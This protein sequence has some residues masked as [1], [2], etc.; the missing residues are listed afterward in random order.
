MMRDEQNLW[1]FLFLLFFIAVFGS[2]LWWL[3]GS[4]RLPIAIDFFD[5]VLVVLAAF[6]LTRLFVYDRILQFFRDWFLDV[7]TVSEEGEVLILR[8]RA[9]RGPRRTITELLGCP[10]CFG[11]WSAATVTFFYFATPLA[12]FPIFV[13]AVAGVTTLF[14]LGANLLGWHTELTKREVIAIDPRGIRGVD[15]DHDH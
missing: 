12:W 8:N 7:S 15:L 9:S 3:W 1:N 4:G 5:S 13:L 10:W 6:R 11:L 14:Q 2:G